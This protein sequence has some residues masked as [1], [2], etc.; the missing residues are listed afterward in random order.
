MVSEALYGSPPGARLVGGPDDPDRL[1]AGY[2]AAWAQ[3]PL[4]DVRV[5]IGGTY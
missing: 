5:T 4:F 1:L 2:R 3:A